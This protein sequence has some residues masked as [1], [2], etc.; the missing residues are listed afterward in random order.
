MKIYVNIAAPKQGN[1]SKEMPYKN[2][3]DAAQ[4]AKAGD[5]ILVAPGVYRE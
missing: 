2:I 4:A 3:N 5:E 1:G